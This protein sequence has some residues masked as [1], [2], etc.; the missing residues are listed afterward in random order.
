MLTHILPTS[1]P[2][3]PHHLPLKMSTSNENDKEDCPSSSQNCNFACPFGGTWY[4]CPDE[5]YFIGCC[6]SDPCT[7]TVTNTSEICPSI[8]TASFNRALFSE[9]RPNTCIG[10]PNE[11]WYTCNH[12]EPAFLGCCGVNPCVE[13]GCPVEELLPAAWSSSRGDQFELFR[14]GDNERDGDEGEDGGEGLSGGAIAGIVVGVVAGVLIIAGLGWFLW[15]KRRTA[16][17][18][19][20]MAETVQPMYTENGHLNTGS[21]YQGMSIQ[22]LSRRLADDQTRTFPAPEHRPSIPRARQLVPRS[23]RRSLRMA[24]RSLRS[25]VAMSITGLSFTGWVLRSRIRFPSWR[26]PISQ[27]CTS[28][29][30]VI[31]DPILV[32]FPAS[33]CNDS[34]T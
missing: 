30:L 21:P 4:A 29:T 31:V 24:G 3:Q 8:H 2:T 9:I 34:I 32:T 16:G 20:S 10:A 27:R 12:T 28:W 17:R 11:N 1:L 19:S 18:S 25:A 14:D 5:P 23:P 13:G 7:N 26:V 22:I 15:R 33:V 6:S